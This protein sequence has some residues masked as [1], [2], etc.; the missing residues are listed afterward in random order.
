M[1]SIVRFTVFNSQNAQSAIHG[2]RA[3][4]AK[5]SHQKASHIPL[6][7]HL[8]GVIGLNKQVDEQGHIHDIEP[9][10][11]GVHHTK[12]HN[13]EAGLQHS[14][15]QYL[16]PKPHINKGNHPTLLILCL[17]L[18]LLILFFI[19]NSLFKPSY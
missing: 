13:K 1:G 3:K 8:A 12:A 10:P 17:S 18:T 4:A 14:H 11:H 2:W 6:A 15:P 7:H 19:H 9:S 5:K 16:H